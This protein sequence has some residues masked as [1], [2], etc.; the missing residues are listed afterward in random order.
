MDFRG[1]SAVLVDPHP[2]WLRALAPLMSGLGIRPGVATTSPER[3]LRAVAEIQPAVLTTELT[4]GASLVDA[5][6]FIRKAIAASPGLRVIAVSER[7]DAASIDAA[8]DAGCAA[9]VAKSAD[10]DGFR[11][12]VRQAFRH[13]VHFPRPSVAPTAAPSDALE[14][15]ALTPREREILVL[16]AEGHSNA[17]LARMLWVTEQTV[18]FHL[19]NVYRKL[20]VSNRTEAGRWAFANGLTTRASEHPTGEQRDESVATLRGMRP[21]LAAAL[22]R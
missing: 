17:E 2:L 12:A 5:L 22:G 18:K 9:F 8:L 6:E 14:R 20:G 4:L 19:A 16:A 7:D 3:A 1:C 15:A 10:A 11:F 13:S 21:S